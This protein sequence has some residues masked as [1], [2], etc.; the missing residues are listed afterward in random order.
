MLASGNGVFDQA[1]DKV[2][3][4]LGLGAHTVSVIGLVLKPRIIRINAGP[5]HA[6]LQTLQYNRGNPNRPF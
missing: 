3:G 4:F 1:L 6:Q 2:M 5:T